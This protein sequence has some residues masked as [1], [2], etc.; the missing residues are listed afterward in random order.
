MTMFGRMVKV[1]SGFA[2]SRLAECRKGTHSCPMKTPH[3]STA[4]YAE[5]AEDLLVRYEK[6]DFD[7]IYERVWYLLPEPPAQ[8]LDIGAGTGR[9]ADGFAGWGYRVT[10]VEPVAELR[11]G[12]KRLHPSPDI[13]W[14]EDH[15]PNL[16]AVAGRKGAFSVVIL[17]A[18][19]MHLDEDER[20]V[21]MPIVSSLTAPGGV[22][23]MS[24]RHGP[25]PEGRRMFDVSPD[26]TKKLAAKEGL[27][28]VF[29]RL[30]GSREDRN[31]RAGVT[32]TRLVFRMAG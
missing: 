17:S 31:K 26:E 14:I 8:V 24:L 25:V 30:S 28:C 3:P 11:E 22:M 12:A 32:W 4:G 7:E 13:Q 21:A 1:D 20:T 6:M 29:E 9:D 23:I 18:V 19:W 27:D 10:A 16:T 5:E 2:P 15:L